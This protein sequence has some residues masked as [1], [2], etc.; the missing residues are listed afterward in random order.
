MIDKELKI[1]FLRTKLENESKGLDHDD[2]FKLIEYKIGWTQ[3]NKIHSE[4]VNNSLLD[5]ET[6]TKLTKLGRNTLNTLEL[7]HNQEIKDSN[8]KRKKL[9]NESVISD[10]KRKTFWPIIVLG[11]FG[12]IYS[13]IDL[14][15]KIISSTESKENPFSKQKKKLKQS[16]PD[17]LILTKKNQDSL[18]N[19]NTELNN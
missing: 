14:F 16:K 17:T 8:A 10:W 3:Y 5:Y 7:E 13:G 1:L 15:S 2:F 9:H 12:G 19:P 4:Y 11:L 6:Y 18:V